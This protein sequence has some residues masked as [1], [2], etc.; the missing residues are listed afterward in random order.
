MTSEPL[1]LA[2]DTS[3]TLGGVGLSR[4]DS[5]IAAMELGPAGSQAET[6]LVAIDALL[7]DTNWQP[8]DLELVT[9]ALG[10]GS[11][12]GLR[13]G[14]AAAKGIGFAR[15]IPVVGVPT[16]TIRMAWARLVSESVGCGWVAV[17]DARRGDVFL[18][19]GR[20]APHD[21]IDIEVISGPD[22]MPPSEVSSLLEPLRRAA[23]PGAPLVICGEGLPVI[24]AELIESGASSPGGT[25]GLSDLRSV[26]PPRPPDAVR[27]LASLGWR[28]FGREGAPL[29]LEP[30]YIRSPDAR[31][32]ARP[33]ALPLPTAES[34]ES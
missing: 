30:L 26:S 14:L 4:G 1:I 8:G 12:A 32:P 20:S 24:A 25:G 5:A 10:P 22:L 29:L 21:A 34:N 33:V 3:S 13:I 16:T 9:V 31:K 7:R 23:T 11:F 28:Q 18:A 19:R 17:L 27:L 6:I 2:I 15:G